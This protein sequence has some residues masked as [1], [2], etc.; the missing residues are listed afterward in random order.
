M[1]TPL[2]VLRR[3]AGRVMAK[4]DQHQTIAWAVT[5]ALLSHTVLAAVFGVVRDFGRHIRDHTTTV[6]GDVIREARAAARR[7]R[8]RTAGKN[9]SGY[10]SGPK[11]GT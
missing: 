11:G 6:A 2:A 9:T 10:T 5:G 7:R 8:W 3:H 4:A 1:L